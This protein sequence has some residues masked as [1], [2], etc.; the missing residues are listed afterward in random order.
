MGRYLNDARYDAERIEYYH[1]YG[2]SNGYAQAEPHWNR[3]NQLA[4][5]VIYSKKYSCEAPVIGKIVDSMRL[6]MDEMKKR[7]IGSDST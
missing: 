2:G 4:Y 6:L 1:K 3:L 5:R 7:E